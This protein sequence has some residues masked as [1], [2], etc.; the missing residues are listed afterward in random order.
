[1][2]LH[3]Y[4][5]CHVRVRHCY[6]GVSKDV[7][8]SSLDVLTWRH[9]AFKRLLIQQYLVAMLC[10]PTAGLIEGSRDRMSSLLVLGGKGS[11]ILV[12]DNWNDH[13]TFFS[14]YSCQHVIFV[15]S[16]CYDNDFKHVPAP[17]QP[18]HRPKNHVNHSIRICSKVL[19]RTVTLRQCANRLRL[20]ASTEHTLL[21]HKSVER[22]EHPSFISVR[23]ASLQSY[24]EH[25]TRSARRLWMDMFPH[26]F[27]MMWVSG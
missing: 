14:T 16:W 1:M 21:R 17:M 11:K 13:S 12:L 7:R 18:R 25:S 27:F 4:A 22:L 5:T 3:D 8:F 9:A 19:P 15:S 2:P 23:H 6:P 10:I 26:S 20:G 24:F